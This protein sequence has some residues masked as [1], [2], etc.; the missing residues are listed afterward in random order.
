MGKTIYVLHERSTKEHFIALE[1]YACK[2]NITI[3][4]REFLILRYITK[5]ILKLDFKLFV[6]Q[7]KN[8]LFFLTALFSSKRKIIIGI[9]P[10]DFYLPFILLFFQRHNLFYFTSWG[11]W[12]GNF[13]PKKKF[14]HLSY[15]K[16]TWQY[17]LEKKVKGIFCVTSFAKQNMQQNFKISCPIVVVSHAVNNQV[18][19]KKIEKSIID[20][21][22]INLVYAGRLLESKG[23]RELIY[24][25]NKLDQDKYSL[26]IIGNGP[27]RKLVEQ[28]AKSQKNIQYLGYVSSKEQLFNI[29]ANCDLQ[30]LFSKKNK[31]STWEELFGMVIIEALYCGVITVATGHVGPKSI[32]NDGIDGF[33]I[34]EDHIIEETMAILESNLFLGKEE[35]AKN[36]AKQFY[37][38]N[39]SKKWEEILINFI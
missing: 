6:Q 2:N 24:L 31:T 29:Y 16:K 7:I 25:M 5:S 32:I 23:I 36:K 11:D 34:N 30:L 8:F 3:K 17:F 9:A 20:N 22:K 39:L 10:L 26:K 38:S 15:I 18:K 35:L 19:F 28:A 1:H 37:K 13:F 12:S 33:L 21:N 4:Y 14:S 27:L